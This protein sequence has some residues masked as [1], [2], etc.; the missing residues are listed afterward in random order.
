M[1]DAVLDA[2][3]ILAWLQDEPG[4]DVVE[5]VMTNRTCLVSSVNVCEVISKL[6]ERGAEREAILEALAAMR[7]VNSDFGA[8]DAL[9]AG[10]LRPTTRGL[11][12]S[13]ADRACLAL[14][15]RLDLPVLTT[16]RA[17]A[18]LPLPIA[19]TIARPA[20]N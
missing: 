11:G 12:L 3:A 19:V 8:A 16:D 10:L 18:A 20:E 15:I 14:A 1:T 6:A 9:E 13:L 17:W 2:S 5:D 4:K 7:F